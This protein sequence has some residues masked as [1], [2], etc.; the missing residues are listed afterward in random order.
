MSFGYTVL[1]FGG[2]KGGASSSSTAYGNRG[3]YSSG[4]QQAPGTQPVYTKAIDYVAIDTTGNASDFGDTGFATYYG[5]GC[6]GD[7]R[8]LCN[9]GGYSIG[10]TAGSGSPSLVDYIEYVT[11]LVD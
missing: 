2:G 9:M 6:A 7:G 11:I 8:G 4:A 10:A 1:G 3:L 5:T